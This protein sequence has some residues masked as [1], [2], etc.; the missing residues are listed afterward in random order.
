MSSLG[1]IIPFC[2][3]LGSF[4]KRSRSS[5]FLHLFLILILNIYI[6]IASKYLKYRFD[7]FWSTQE[8]KY[9]GLRNWK[10]C[11]GFTQEKFLSSESILS[12]SPYVHTLLTERHNFWW[13]TLKN[14]I[15]SSKGIIVLVHRKFGSFK[16][17]L[18]F[19]SFSYLFLFLILNIYSNSVK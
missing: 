14:A 10:I 6:Q 15:P 12:L 13:V 9:S 17:I 16:K 7:P 8:I 4:K 2:V 19:S 1:I 3:K 11:W 18:R 5:S